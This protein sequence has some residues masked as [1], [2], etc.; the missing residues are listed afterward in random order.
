MAA[1]IQFRRD[2][3]A[4][5]TAA[6]PILAEGE[7]GWEIDT[8]AYKLGDGIREW[9]DLPYR[10]LAPSVT[11]LLLTVGDTEPGSPAAGYMDLYSKAIAGRAMP[12]IVGPSG[13]DTALQPLLARNKVGYWCPPGNGVIAPGVLGYTSPTITT[14]A[15]RNVAVTNMFTRMRRMGV[16]ST[17][18][19]GNVASFRVAAAQFTLGDGNGL[20]GF[21]KVVRFGISDTLVVSTARM[22]MGMWATTTAIGNVEPSTLTNFIGVGHGAAD[23]NFKIFYGGSIA[24]TPIDLGSDFPSNTTNTDVYELALFAP[25]SMSSTVYYE[26]TR[27]NTG[28]VATGTLTGTSGTVVPAPT[29]LLCPHQ[30]MRSN[31]TV[32]AVVGFDVMSD[33]IETDQ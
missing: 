4:I 30:S 6:N 5:W 12:K 10:E 13:L 16:T 32:A 25:P 2:T 31:N 15:T 19:I 29:T 24:Q 1:L 9:T 7:P 20:G 21:F 3:A 17:A 11:S 22:A 33:Y 8:G 28:H 14:A 26:V 27:L 23:T 18:A